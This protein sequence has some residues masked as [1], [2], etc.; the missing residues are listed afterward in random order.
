MFMR[1]KILFIFLESIKYA[2]FVFRPIDFI[3]GH[4]ELSTV[5]GNVKVGKRSSLWQWQF[6]RDSNEKL[7]NFIIQWLDVHIH[8]N[9]LCVA[10]V[11]NLALGAHRMESLTWTIQTP[12]A[13]HFVHL[14][15]CFCSFLIANELNAD[16]SFLT[17]R[18]HRKLFKGEI[19]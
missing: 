14:S 17:S 7:F 4:A 5:N 15:W 16:S 8:L 19:Q 13:S 3:I 18:T 9:S 6:E 11:M 10:Y 12:L 1:S 2:A